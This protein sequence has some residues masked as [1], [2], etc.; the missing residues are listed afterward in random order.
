MEAYSQTLCR[1]VRRPLMQM[2]W[3]DSGWYTWNESE[4]KYISQVKEPEEDITSERGVW[5][6]QKTDGYISCKYPFKNLD[7]NRFVDRYSSLKEVNDV[8]AL[9]TW[10]IVNFSTLSPFIK[11]FRETI[12][13]INYT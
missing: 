5:S 6:D 8:N 1:N 13:C 7:N 10:L 3:N 9:V 4:L 2:I 12:L 11:S